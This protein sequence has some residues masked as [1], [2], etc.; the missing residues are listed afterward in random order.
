MENVPGILTIGDGK[1]LAAI[2]R[3]MT[4]L[5]YECEARI[6]FAEDFGVPQERRRVFFVGTR[7]G[8]DS[9]L[10]PNGT[11]GPA[12]KPSKE[13]NPWVH[14]WEPR[15]GSKLPELV[16][17]WDALSDL[18][19]L[20]NGGGKWEGRHSRTA[21]TDFQE[22]ARVRSGDGLKNHMTRDLSNAMLK[23]IATV[24]AGGNWRDIPRP[25]LTKGMRR[26]NRSDH[27]KRYGRPRRSELSCTILTK[28]DPHWGAY[29]HPTQDRVISVREAARLQSFGDHF[30]FRGLV[31]SQYAQVGNAVPPALARAI[32]AA[33]KRHLKRPPKRQTRAQLKLVRESLAAGRERTRQLRRRLRPAA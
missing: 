6:L 7:M 5:G 28:C 21:Q 14:H 20:K 17:V 11:H 24:P 18:P 30:R 10:F 29:I 25:L 31:H 26:A 13:A 16:T 2:T 1:V 9:K 33:V 15:R 27:T 4:K 3:E 8:W 32:A 12:A 23:R 19:R 22:R